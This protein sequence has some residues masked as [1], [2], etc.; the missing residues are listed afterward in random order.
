MKRNSSPFKR[1][2]YS[3][4]SSCSAFAG[5]VATDFLTCDIEEM[6]HER[7]L[8]PEHST[9]FRCQ[10]YGAEINTRIRPYLEM[11]GMSS[12]VDEMYIKVGK[13]CKYL[14]RAV[15]KQDKTIEFMLAPNATFLRQNDSLR[16]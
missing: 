12:H 2:H 5:I 10:R 16:R 8:P 4:A 11:R 13:Q 3:P 15:D 7:G 14:Y 9:V 6:M 1:R